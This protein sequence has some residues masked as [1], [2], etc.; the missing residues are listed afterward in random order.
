[1]TIMYLLASDFVLLSVSSEVGETI[2]EEVK[3]YIY[4]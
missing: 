2:G 4:I 3:I 1:M